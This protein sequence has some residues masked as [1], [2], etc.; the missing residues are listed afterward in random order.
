MTTN[1]A[2]YVLAPATP[3]I[4]GTPTADLTAIILGFIAVLLVVLGAMASAP[5][6]LGMAVLAA[7]GGVAAFVKAS[8]NQMK[9]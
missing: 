2:S 4:V 6:V 1:P 3:T 9:I 5:I 7:L 8:K